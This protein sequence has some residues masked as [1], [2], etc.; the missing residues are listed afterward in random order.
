MAAHGA[1]A[2]SSAT[3]GRSS[4]WVLGLIPLALIAT[5][6]ALFATLGAPGLGER[7]GPLAEEL[8][9][10]KTV[11]RP[12]EIELTVPN[13]GPDPVGVTQ[14]AVNDAYV[15]FKASGTPETGTNRAPGYREVDD[16][17]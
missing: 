5:A 17:V 7:R 16:P 12:G 9:V 3:R 4:V 6:V 1:S 13:D 10:E 2:G 8:L 11:L 14:V 15:D